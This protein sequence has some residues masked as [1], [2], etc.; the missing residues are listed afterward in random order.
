MTAAAENEGEQNDDEFKEKEELAAGPKV[1]DVMNVFLKGISA[2]GSVFGSVDSAAR[3]RRFGPDTGKIDARDAHHALDHYVPP[4]CQE[5]VEKSL[6]DDHVVVIEGL[7][8]S[9][10]RAGALS[11]LRGR[12]AGPL[13]ALSPVITPSELAEREYERDHGYLVVDMVDTAKEAD[14]DF[15]WAAVRDVVRDAGAF[16]VITRTAAVPEAS[17][18]VR[19]VFWERSDVETVLRAHLGED[20]DAVSELVAAVPE[21]CPMGD[22]ADVAARVAAGDSVQEALRHLDIA[23]AQTVREWFEQPR[24]RKEIVEIAAL[25]FITGVSEREY[26]SRLARLEAELEVL[27]PLPEQEPV[28]GGTEPVLEQSRAGRLGQTSLM[29]TETVIWEQTAVRVLDFKD[30]GYRLCVLA[31]LN[32]RM[33]TPFWDAVRAWIH[34]IVGEGVDFDV[35]LG[36]AL[37]A[38]TDAGEVEQS[39]LEP[40]SR[41]ELDD[42]GRDT[43]AIVLWLMCFDEATVPVALRVVR[44][45]AL[46]GT[47]EQ[48]LTAALA[49]SGELAARFPTE[50]VRRVWKLLERSTEADDEAYVRAFAVLFATLV[51]ETDNGATALGLL[52]RVLDDFEVRPPRMRR[53]E[54]VLRSVLAVLTVHGGPEH[55]MVICHFIRKRP[56]RLGLVARLWAAVLRNRIHRRAAVLALL[57]CT[58]LL[59]PEETRGLGEALADAMPPDELIPLHESLVVVRRRGKRS[60]QDA[61]IDVLLGTLQN[62]NTEGPTP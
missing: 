53:R 7:R 4:P 6:R 43:A 58:D 37:L 47:R 2:P 60:D 12:T 55:Q 54:L 50:A 17:G 59:T 19:H 31:E 52:A 62:R 41:G 16:L 42:E 5:R 13:V 35:A 33:P 26:E 49:L 51:H 44:G 61:L 3:G 34:Q 24:T 10:K 11:M 1:A 21:D 23:S 46:F 8:G 30:P 45:W 28:E 29:K 40:W 22:L 36:L 48:R 32:R 25:A 15:V 18:S 27:L 14:T 38:E 20:S 56:D 9:G 57:R 39:Y